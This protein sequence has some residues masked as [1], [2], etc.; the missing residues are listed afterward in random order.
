[1]RRKNFLF[2]NMVTRMEVQE[3]T[4][5]EQKLEIQIRRNRNNDEAKQALAIIKD[6][7]RGRN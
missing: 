1:M 4:E 5:R 3:L 6:E 2:K 7:L